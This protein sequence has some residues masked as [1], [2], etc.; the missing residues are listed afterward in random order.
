[1]SLTLVSEQPEV[2]IEEMIDELHRDLAFRKAT[3]PMM[4][5]DGLLTQ[6]EADRRIFVLQSTLRTL[7]RLAG[8]LDELDLAPRMPR[9][10]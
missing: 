6:V 4:I 9:A 2:T 8:E 5:A 1:M 7:Q 3:Y 10:R